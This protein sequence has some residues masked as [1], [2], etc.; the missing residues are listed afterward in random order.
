[1]IWLLMSMSLFSFLIGGFLIVWLVV[2]CLRIGVGL[3]RFGLSE[4]LMSANGSLGTCPVFFFL[5]LRPFTII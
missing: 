1:M 5:S 4:K 2:R 3:L